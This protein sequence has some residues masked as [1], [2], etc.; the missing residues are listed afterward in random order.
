MRRDIAGLLISELP[1]QVRNR[2]EE[3]TL[4]ADRAV[5]RVSDTAAAIAARAMKRRTR[6]SLEERPRPQL[7]ASPESKFS[8]NLSDPTRFRLVS[9]N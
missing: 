7:L 8:W 4:P 2:I 1:A 3:T 5:Q 6:S 9:G